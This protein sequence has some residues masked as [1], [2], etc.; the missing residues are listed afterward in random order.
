M[1][2]RILAFAQILTVGFAATAASLSAEDQ[3]DFNRQIRPILSDL[4]F[5]CHGPDNNQRQ[6][7]L[8]LDTAE[9]ARAVLESGHA[10]IVPSDPAAST[11]LSRIVASDPDV[12]MPPP[13]TGKSATPAQ[14]ELLT[15]WIRQ[16]AEY[17]GHWSFI[18]PE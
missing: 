11:I 12:V 16:G 6:A 17:R 3:I 13:A 8:R 14:V 18:R 2:S 9:G 10:A 7:G 5:S 4:C 1:P 15:A